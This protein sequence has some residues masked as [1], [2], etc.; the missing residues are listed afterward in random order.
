MI[1]KRSYI[2]LAGIV[3]I[4]SLL[5][6]G[7]LSTKK[8][9]TK[10]DY[11]ITEQVASDFMDSSRRGEIDQAMQHI[12]DEVVLSTDSG[13]MKGKEVIEE[14]LKVNYE[15]NNRIEVL[16]KN[17]VD[18][19][20]IELIVSNQIPLFQIA[21]VD[22]IK[23]KETLEVQ[24]G[25]IVKWE[26]KHLKESVD[27]VEKVASGTTGLEAEVREGKIVVTKVLDK[28]PARHAGLKKG[29]VILAINGIELKDMEYGEEEI[30]Y[31][32]IGEAGSSVS[33]DISREGETFNLDLRR[34]DINELE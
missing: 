9:E 3:L 15:K 14:M 12:D 20:K 28:T 13:Q 33:V 11:A 10:P 22:V 5:L 17:K 29:D 31:R 27:L 18:N 34:V 6:S 23:T 21:G 7:C 4:I 30:P 8:Y 26:I 1:K 25:K 16:E 24:D 2:I 19:S 32:L